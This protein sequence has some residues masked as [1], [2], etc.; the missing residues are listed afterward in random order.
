MKSMNMRLAAFVMAAFALLASPI[1]SQAAEDKNAGLFVNLTTLDTSR[2]GHALM[3]AD[4]ARKRGHPVVIFLNHKAA[5]IAAEG[6]PHPSFKGRTLDQLLTTAIADG[7]TVVVCK[8]CLDDH[9][10]TEPNLVE[11]AVISSPE[12]VH[13]Y[14]FDP[15]YKVMTW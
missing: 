12:V 7:A 6:V 1:A 2:A 13:G 9:G 3:L 14:L 15:A 5:L 11:G 8:M 4:G 10:L